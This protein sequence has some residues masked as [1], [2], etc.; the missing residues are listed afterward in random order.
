MFETDDPIVKECR[1]MLLKLE[2]GW[3]KFTS[4][5]MCKYDAAFVYPI[6]SDGFTRALKISQ[7]G[8]V[9]NSK[10]VIF[11]FEKV[12]P[13]EMK[14]TNSLLALKRFNIKFHTSFD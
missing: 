3:V 9:C 2:F 12:V 11:G 8:Y 1:D 7:E 6:E 13:K 5:K 4:S 10:N 14:K